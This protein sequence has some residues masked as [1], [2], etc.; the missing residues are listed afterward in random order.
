[1]ETLDREHRAQDLFAAD[2]HCTAYCLKY[3][4]QQIIALLQRWLA[5]SL[6]AS[7]ES[8]ALIEAR[9]NEAFDALTVLGGNQRTEV[10]RGIER[11]ADLKIR[12]CREEAIHK[13]L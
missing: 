3:R 8:R 12:H 10:S 2:T 6:A 4:G 5:R 9:L 7:Q 1:M 13:A 11:V